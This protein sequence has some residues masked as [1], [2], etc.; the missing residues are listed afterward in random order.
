[1]PSPLD[2][3]QRIIL[4]ES[5]LQQRTGHHAH[6][7][8]GLAQR[9]GGSQQ[10]LV[11]LASQNIDP[12]LAVDLADPVRAFTRA[13]WDPVAVGDAFDQDWKD[14]RA[15]ARRYAADLDLAG[16]EPRSTDLF[17]MP[18]ARAREAAGLADWLTRHKARARVALG[19]QQL[20]RPVE[21]GNV[22][23][24]V[25][26]LAARSLLDSVG[27]ERIFAYATNHRLARRLATAM[28]LGIHLAPQP[29]FY[30][31]SATAPFP[32]A[33][34]AGDGPL[35]ACV[36][37]PRPEKTALALASLVRGA[38]DLRR[39][40]RFVIQV[41][42]TRLD[43]SLAALR[44]IPQVALVKGWLDDADFVALIRAA[45]MLLLPYQR[46]RYA[47]RTSGPFA[48]AAAAGKPAIVPSGTW[49]ADRIARKQAAGIAYARDSAIY[50]AL[51]AAAA[52][53]PLLQAQAARLAPRWRDWDG[54]ELLRLI[55]QW[56]AGGGI[57][58]IRRIDPGS[59]P[60]L[61]RADHVP[62]PAGPSPVPAP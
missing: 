38:L 18:T 44:E 41:N 46:E 45:D 29:V 20:L 54:E 16:I 2:E 24:L 35:V 40:L 58:G 27:E 5:G 62:S 14:F 43:P 36:G 60:V 34:P 48:L 52:R 50:D 59:S 21:A 13:W 19:F 11:I 56:S 17:W 3:K 61:S 47:E 15:G 32:G 7:A 6:F 4:L 9:L 57:R 22:E 30:N 31:L 53:L 49:M 25:H 12:R 26:R 10:P 28:N 37:V 42:G 55:L 51:A 1:V 33:L 39:D 8:C 23:G